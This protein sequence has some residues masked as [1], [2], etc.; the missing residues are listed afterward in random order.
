MFW[1]HRTGTLTCPK[2]DVYN[3]CCETVVVVGIRFA[4]R[5]KAIVYCSIS[6]LFPFIT[7][8]CAE[9]FVAFSDVCSDDVS[10]FV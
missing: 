2:I 3:E 6:V 5:T 10:V 1:R 7:S 4:D 9:L 8:I